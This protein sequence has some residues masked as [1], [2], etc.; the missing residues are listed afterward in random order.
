VFSDEAEV[1][2][3]AK[4]KRLEPQPWDWPRPRVLLELPD[5]ADSRER[6]DALRRAGYSIAICAGPTAEG[7]C[8]LAGDEG[9]A[10]AHDADIVVSGLGL[11]TAQAR[12]PL[13]AL[14]TRLPQL[15]V[16]V[17]ADAEAAAR[18]PDLIREEQRL[19]PGIDSAELVSRVNEALGR[20]PGADA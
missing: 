13:A 7:H 5:R 19:E 15:P 20:K 9:C 14:R 6:I 10:A 18:W 12:E 4:G 11:D 16:L 8:P 2:V 17:E 1:S 3:T